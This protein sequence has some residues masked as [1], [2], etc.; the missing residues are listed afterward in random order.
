M[1]NNGSL[2]GPGGRAS[3]R[4]RESMALVLGP[5][6]M[7]DVI[8][9]WR[10]SR[11]CG[12][13]NGVPEKRRRSHPERIT[14]TVRTQQ[15]KTP[16]EDRW[17]VLDHRRQIWWNPRFVHQESE[18]AG[19]HRMVPGGSQVL[20]VVGRSEYERRVNHLICTG[21]AAKLGDGQKHPRPDSQERILDT[22]FD[23]KAVGPTDEATT[24]EIELLQNEGQEASEDR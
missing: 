1:A 9:R 3:I 19:A 7:R 15:L 12:S 22:E 17:F 24:E 21:A 2:C 16:L 23:V 8:Y 6:E 18:V 20:E 13:L 5:P 14:S 11:P 4:T 10:P